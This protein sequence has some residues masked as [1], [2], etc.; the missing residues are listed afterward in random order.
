MIL[1]ISRDFLKHGTSLARF[2]HEGEEEKNYWRDPSLN[3]D[4]L[5]REFLNELFGVEFF[6]KKVSGGWK[7]A[8]RVDN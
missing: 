7:K 3:S 8:R 1:N 5:Q 2:F 4:K 6:A